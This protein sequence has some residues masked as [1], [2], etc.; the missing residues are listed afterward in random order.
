MTGQHIRRTV[1]RHC[2]HF[3]RCCCC[4]CGGNDLLLGHEHWAHQSHGSFPESR[5][6]SHGHLQLEAVGAEGR[7]RSL[8]SFKYVT[9]AIL[10]GRYC[11]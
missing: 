2:S 4:C 11:L 5:R 1:E 10:A 3:D 8:T 9:T 7:N 6:N